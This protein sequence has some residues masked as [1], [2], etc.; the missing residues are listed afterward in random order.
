MVPA[1]A[2]SSPLKADSSACHDGKGINDAPDGWGGVLC[3][4]AAA[5]PSN[6][7]FVLTDREQ[8]RPPERRLQGDAST[9]EHNSC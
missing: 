3:S 2:F 7:K 1:P 4:G 8:M 9:L 5:P 6:A